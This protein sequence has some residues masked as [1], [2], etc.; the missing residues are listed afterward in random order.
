MLVLV[1]GSWIRYYTPATLKTPNP[2]SFPQPN[3]I[4]FLIK[5]VSFTR[6]PLPLT[7]PALRRAAALLEKNAIPGDQTIIVLRVGSTANMCSQRILT[8]STQENAFFIVSKGV[9]TSE[10]RLSDTKIHQRLTF[11]SGYYQNLIQRA[12]KPPNPLSFRALIIH[13]P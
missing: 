3:S 1:F 10:V 9:Y 12:E 6:G 8:K 2:H 4:V 11:S 7:P 5:P 13:D